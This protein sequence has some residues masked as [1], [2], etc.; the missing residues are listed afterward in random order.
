M[1]THN[2]RMHYSM[3]ICIYQRGEEQQ[4]LLYIGPVVRQTA[5]IA[6][7]GLDNIDT[8]TNT[9]T[10]TNTNTRV[11]IYIYIYI[12]IYN[13]NNTHTLIIIHIIHYYYY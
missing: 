10:D 5:L 8:N 6:V 7:E 1:Y 9:D 13:N 4:P 12:Y 11:Y 3:H 2:V